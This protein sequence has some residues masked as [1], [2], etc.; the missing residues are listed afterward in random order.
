MATVVLDADGRLR[1]VSV[2]PQGGVVEAEAAKR[3]WP[4]LFADAGLDFQQFAAA[5]ATPP[6]IAHDSRIAWEGPAASAATR[7]RVTG[8]SL[9]QQIVFFDVAAVG[10]AP[11]AR[12]TW[13]S[14]GA[15]SPGNE[16]L[17]VAA[18]I[19]LFIGGGILARR[20]RGR[21]RH[22]RAPPV[23]AVAVGGILGR[24]ARPHIPQPVDE[25][26]FC[27]IAAGRSWAG[28][29]GVIYI[30]LEPFMR[31]WWPHVDLVGASPRGSRATRWSDETLVRLLAGVVFVAVLILR[32][33]STAAPAFP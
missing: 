12:Q 7:L 18:T 33:G 25:W 3:S 23:P 13:Y 14:R 27:D 19:L 31:K 8:A 24:A 20:N 16:A 22:A 5:A 11:P 10:A 17:L 26:M 6:L 15:R 9:D 29:A 30:S 28:F 4:D 21:P 2:V 32:V 1:R